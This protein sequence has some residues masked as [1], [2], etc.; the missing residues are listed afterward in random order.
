MTWMIT[1]EFNQ[2]ISKSYRVQFFSR[3]FNQVDHES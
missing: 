1:E 3:H 2:V